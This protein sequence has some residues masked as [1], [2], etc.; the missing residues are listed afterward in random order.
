MKTRRSP[1]LSWPARTW[2]AP[3]QRTSA[4]AQA[5]RR[6]MVRSRPAERRLVLMSA[7]MAL[8]SLP[9]KRWR[10]LFSRVRDW[11]VR[12]AAMLSDAVAAS[13]PSRL[14]VRRLASWMRRLLCLAEY[15]MTGSGM[16]ESSANCQFSASMTANMPAR[17]KMLASMGRRAETVT[18]LSWE[19][20]FTRRRVRS[21]GR[22]FWW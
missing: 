19:T 8:S 4:V 14:R 2:R 5:T 1:A 18:S 6:S 21:P 7:F 11:T 20:S 22:I 17:T 12:M 3:C 15:H 10:N 9:S 13:A 16:R